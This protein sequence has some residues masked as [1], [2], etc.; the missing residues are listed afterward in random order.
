MKKVFNFSELHFSKVTSYKIHLDTNSKIHTLVVS[1]CFRDLLYNIVPV[2][3]FK[4][5]FD[6]ISSNGHLF[7]LALFKKFP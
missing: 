7:F 6:K 4:V 2:N 3:V 1:T 5:C